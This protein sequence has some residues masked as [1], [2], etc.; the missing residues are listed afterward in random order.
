MLMARSAEMFGELDGDFER[1]A[2]LQRSRLVKIKTSDH[3]DPLT[4]PRA[5]ASIKLPSL[6]ENDVLMMRAEQAEKN[7]SSLQVETVTLAARRFRQSLPD[8]R[9]CGY[10]IGDGTGCGKGR[11]IAALMTHMWN[12]GVKRHVWVSATNDLYYDACRDLKDLGADIPC[13]TL[14]RLPPSAPL[15]KW[16]TEANKELFKHMGAEGDGVIFVTYS[17]LVQTGQR[18]QLMAVPVK[19]E[20]VRSLLLSGGLLDEKLKVTRKV[21]GFVD[22]NGSAMELHQGDRI[23]SVQELRQIQKMALPFTLTVERV[24]HKDKSEKGSADAGADNQ[25]LTAWNSR[26]GQLVEW[27]GGEKA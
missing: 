12:S 2:L 22:V 21:A 4:E 1:M 25:D 13:I 20:E 5:T 19:T 7:L 9:T 3:P 6:C 26:L 27:M 24:L 10:A 18:R 11:C 8:G 23:A 14:R 16:G 17:L 15:D